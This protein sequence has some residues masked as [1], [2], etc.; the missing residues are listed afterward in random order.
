MGGH[1]VYM[2]CQDDVAR[3]LTQC[4][5]SEMSKWI[6]HYYRTSGAMSWSVFKSAPETANF[7]ESHGWTL[8]EYSHACYIECNTGS[9]VSIQIY[10]FAT[11]FDYDAYNPYIT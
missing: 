10:V 8:A 2:T 3:K 4:S 9:N 6:K 11:L 1:L 5:F 7:I